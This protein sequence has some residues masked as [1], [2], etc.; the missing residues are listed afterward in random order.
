MSLGSNCNCVVVHHSQAIIG[1]S[2]SI[3]FRSGTPQDIENDAEYRRLK[4]FSIHDN[5]DDV[6]GT[7]IKSGTEAMSLR[8]SRIIKDNEEVASFEER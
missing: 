1:A 8:S 7:S 5:D 2:V 4:R 3:R 6:E